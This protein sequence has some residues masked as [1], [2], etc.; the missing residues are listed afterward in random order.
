[1]DLHTTLT[2]EGPIEPGAT[3][4]VDRKYVCPECGFFKDALAED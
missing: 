1:M 2:G 3:V 4:K